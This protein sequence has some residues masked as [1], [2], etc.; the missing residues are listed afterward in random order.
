MLVIVGMVLVTAFVFGGFIIAG[1]HIMVIVEAAAI[2]LFIIGGGALGA[3][4][5]G[6]SMK[7]VKAS[8][9]GIIALLKPP[10]FQRADYI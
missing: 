7:T 8:I 2:E 6:N 1:G 10:P 3:F 5:V 9:A 4:I